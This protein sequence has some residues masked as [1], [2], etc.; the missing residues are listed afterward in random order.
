M[1]ALLY[2]SFQDPRPCRLVIVG[3]F[4]DMGGID[5]V[6]IPTAHYMIAF[7]IEFEDGYLQSPTQ[8]I[9]TGEERNNARAYVAVGCGIYCIGIVG[10]HGGQGSF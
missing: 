5:K 2:F 6:V 4:E 8:Y 9:L 10:R 7:Y 1:V 3:D